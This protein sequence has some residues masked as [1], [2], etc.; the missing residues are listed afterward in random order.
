MENPAEVQELRNK[1]RMMKL[2]QDDIL[3]TVRRQQR[4][5]HK[6]KQAN[7][8]IR[9]EIV[10]YEAQIAN[11]DRDIQNY[12]SNEELQKLQTY[13]KNL[14]N[15]LSILSA[16]LAA[17]EQKR[18]KLEEDVSKANSKAGGLFQQSKE[19]EELQAKLR[20]IENRLD[21]ALV[22]Y[23]NNL[24]KLSG[25]RAQIDELRKDRFTFREVIRNTE[26]DRLKKDQ[27]I[28]NLITNSNDA[29]S[30]RDRLKMDLVQL[31]QAEAEDIKNYEEEYSRLTQQ[32]EGQRI[33]QNRPRDQQQTVPSISS[34]I[35][36]QTDQQQEEITALTEQYN[37]TIQQT[38]D[39]FGYKDVQELFDEADKLE[40]EN[41]SL[42]NFVVEKGAKRSKMQEEIEGLNLQH[43]ALM[44]QVEMNDSDQK[45]QLDHVT[46]D[47][48]VINGD[49]TSVKEE[50]ERNEAEF[51]S[52]YNEIEN[53]FNNLE[54]NWGDSPDEKQNVTPQNAMFCLS[55]IE[56]AI[57][58]MMNNVAEKA[59]LQYN[60]RGIQDF[61][62][63]LGEDRSDSA[64]VKPSHTKGM[65]DKEAAA[66]APKAFEG[67]ARPMT[68]DEMRAMLG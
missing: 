57:A 61:T 47:I 58:E 1:L 4:A 28:G 22:R 55:T 19:N 15:K 12:K 45:E 24:T 51:A 2:P 49:L 30:K 54:C 8:T 26:N 29:Y 20:T 46:N 42:F 52:V 64:G 17:E 33:T 3:N 16:D 7:D 14:S 6:Q 56:T 11:L 25:L 18:K 13:K 35:G 34:Q 32:I 50:K 62:T 41:F 53:L 60:M 31:K 68:I 36:S 48:K 37:T 59:K 63:I 66:A 43:D 38:L 39:L 9:N 27:E 10:E 21:K 5:I 23:N 67:V 40:R 44:A 65:S